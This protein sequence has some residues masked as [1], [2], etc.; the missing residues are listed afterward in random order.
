MSSIRIT[1]LA[2][3]IDTDQIIS[4]LMKAERT[5]VDKVEQE[6]QILQ[7]RQELYNSVNKDFANFILNTKK[8]FG[9][10][11]T[12]ST[13]QMLNKSLSSLKWVKRAT[14]TNE[15]AVTVSTTASSVNGSYDMTV[16]RLA[17]GVK[18]ASRENISI[19]EDKT[20]LAS[21]FGLE[22]DD[23]IEFSIKTQHGEV[24]FTFGNPDGSIAEGEESDPDRP[25]SLSELTMSDVVKAINSAK[26]SEGESLGIQASYDSNIDRFFIQTTDTGTDAQLLIN[27]DTAGDSAGAKFINALKLNVTAYYNTENEDVESI[28]SIENIEIGDK[29]THELVIGEA[30]YGVNAQIDFNGAMGIEQS[31]NQFTIN[32]ISF[33]LKSTGTS[34]VTVD[35]DVDSVYDKIKSFVD[36]YNEIVDK[37]G[38][39]LIEK[40]YSDFDPLTDEQKEEMTEKEIELWEEKAKSGLLRNDSIISSIMSNV[41]SSLYENV[42]DIEGPFKAIYEIGIT[43]EK[44]TT[45][46]VGGRLQIDEEK[47]KEKIA[48][49]VDGVLELLFKESSSTTEEESGAKEYTGGVITRM[50]DIMIDGMKEVINKA[51][52]GEDANLYRNIR[53]N[54]LIDFV[55][56]H[57]SISMI[58]DEISD[59]NDKIY[60]LN[61][62]LASKEDQYYS[63]FAAM[64][65]YVQQMNNQGSWL[66]QQF[67]M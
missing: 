61:V 18:A 9:L 5:R 17:D 8:E 59:L 27:A 21:Q 56:K 66:M 26:T 36:E 45:G 39:L 43:T 35:T 12:T 60:D 14:S 51:G 32:G 41:R 15:G 19:G 49:D 13:G 10:T 29:F 54:M 58:D 57:G 1:G 20:N 63:K 30:F 24:S 52:T 40:K 37:M 46:T 53:Y 2:T 11:T 64:E 67:G 38:N 65:K 44:W 7:W 28:K 4:D 62:Y 48:E 6:K 55:T 33:D 25:K 16:H 23:V 3:G 47:L 31:S 42:E 34:T 50:Y 22:E